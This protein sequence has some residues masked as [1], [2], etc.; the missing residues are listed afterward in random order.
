MSG[1]A[2]SC[3]HLDQGLQE[4][5]LLWLDAAIREQGQGLDHH[6]SLELP[7]AD[8]EHS[9]LQVGVCRQH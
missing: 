4:T 6:E 3:T 5:D 9:L 8:Q 1:L 2:D 7:I